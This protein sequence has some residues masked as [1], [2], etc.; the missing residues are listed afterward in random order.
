MTKLVD[1]NLF[2]LRREL[3]SQETIFGLSGMSNR[4]KAIFAFIAQGDSTI[5]KIQKDDY[6]KNYSLST[7]K[8]A[9]INLTNR[10]MVTS[11]ISEYDK[12]ERILSYRPR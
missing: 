2:E 1:I 7:I 12:R 11:K 3:H 10:G 8:R 5:T 4:E 9:I 6:F